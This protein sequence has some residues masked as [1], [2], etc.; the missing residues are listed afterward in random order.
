MT[1]PTTHVSYPCKDAFEV[2]RTL[3]ELVVSLDRIGSACAGITK[4]ELDAAVSAFVQVHDIFRKAS[5]ARSIMSAPFS[6]D[7]G[8]DGTED[9]ERAMQ[10]VPYWKARVGE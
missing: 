2:L 1:V 7:V 9:L 5:K 4:T 8:P 6:S 3:E 10:D